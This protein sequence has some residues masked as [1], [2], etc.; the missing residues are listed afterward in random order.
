MTIFNPVQKLFQKPEVS[1]SHLQDVI[2]T[3]VIKICILWWNY[4]HVTT[5]NSIIK[6]FWYI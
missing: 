4:V 6:K 1:E 5:I 3:H 2:M